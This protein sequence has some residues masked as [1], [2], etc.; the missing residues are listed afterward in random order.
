MDFPAVIY[1]DTNIIGNLTLGE[2]NPQFIELKEL[3]EQ[4]RK[5][6]GIKFVLPQVV[7]L[8]WIHDHWDNY[9]KKVTQAKTSLAGIE[10]L[11]GI[12]QSKLTIAKDEFGTVVSTYKQKLAK[13]SFSVA[14]TPKNISI[15]QLVIMAAFKIRP[16]EEKGE[17]GF[18]DAIILFTILEDMK[19]NKIKNAIYI[20]RDD[21]FE[22]DDVA[23]K[24]KEYKVGLLMKHSLEETIDYLRNI[25][26]D[27]KKA[28]IDFENKKLLDFLK[29]ESNVIFSFV[30]KNVKI[31]KDFIEKGSFFAKTSEVIGT[32][33]KVETFIPIEIQ[34]AFV[35]EFTRKN[36]KLKAGKIP[37][38]I[39]VGTKLKITYSPFLLWNRPAVKVEDLPNFKEKI[40]STPVKYYGDPVQ[41]EL[42]RSVSVNATVEKDAKGNYVNLELQSAY[43]M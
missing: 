39:S 23:R 38:L 10:N 27:K 31:S 25:L 16:F 14:K 4:I 29:T 12:N 18:R 24:I 13:L 28:S 17:K 36:E 9:K 32:I 40:L 19:E 33:E 21:I 26:D 2:T 11:S 15:D 34:S 37:L 3:A 5:P 20:S 22:H 42:D 1:F 43:A 8:E 7:S 6:S 41:K 35:N 30:E